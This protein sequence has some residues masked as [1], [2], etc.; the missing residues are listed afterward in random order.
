MLV[1]GH[2][3]TGLLFFALACGQ[4]EPTPTSSPSPT[5]TTAPSPAALSPEHQL[6]V[7]KGCAACHGRNAEGSAFAPPL[8]GHS[9][10]VV[11]RQIRAPLG[12]M[13]VFPLDKISNEEMQAITEFIDGLSA[14]NEHAHA[15][16][17]SGPDELSL[18]HWM[19]LF[20]IEAEDPKEGAHHLGH[21]VDLTEGEHLAQMKKAIALL[22]E[23][24][25]HEGAH[26]VEG[27]LAGLEEVG[28][29]D[30]GMHLTL[31]LSSARVGEHDASLHHLQHFLD[32]A[33]GGRQEAAEEIVSMLQA[34]AA[35]DAVDHLE[36]LAG[37]ANPED[38]HDDGR[39]DEH[40]QDDHNAEPQGLAH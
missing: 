24:E 25:V 13:P 5:S 40:G 10:A 12:I 15:K 23:G 19:A 7:D 28:L 33:S 38:E 4:P 8:A 11:K 18:H 9:A 2:M 29:D 31:A 14:D 39:A 35:H 20:S 21:I 3:F 32:A 17:S 6:F 22:E 27:M 37:Q 26:I 36:E 16:A 34:G 30:S 1:M